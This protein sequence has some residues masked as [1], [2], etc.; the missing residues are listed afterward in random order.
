MSQTD[1]QIAT[2]APIGEP[3]ATQTVSETPSAEA[4]PRPA[5]K[6][7]DEAKRLQGEVNARALAT[8]YRLKYIDLRTAEPDYSL[9]ERLP[10]EF[11]VRNQFVPL[12]MNGG[13]QQIAVAD[14]TNLDLVDELEVILGA[15][16]ERVVASALAI[17][18]ALKRGNTATRI[19]HEKTKELGVSIIRD[20]E[21]GEEVVDLASIATADD[22]TAPV[23][24][25]MNSILFNALERRASDI[26]IETRDASMVVK[27]RSDGALYR[28]HRRPDAR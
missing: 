9:I 23:I 8:R 17:E 24:Q 26:H 14:P 7:A 20:T 25:L 6:P 4:S 5:G 2:T 15:R 16:L 3:S 11:L 1:E 28:Q 10:V 27:Y 21:Q 19:M 22:E 18:E 12:E 13:R